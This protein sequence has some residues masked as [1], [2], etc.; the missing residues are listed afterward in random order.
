MFQRGINEKD[1]REVLKNGE[2][3]EERPDDLPYPSR[4]MLGFVD[5]AHCTLPHLMIRRSRQRL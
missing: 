2:T 3:I 4:L 1:V 5:V